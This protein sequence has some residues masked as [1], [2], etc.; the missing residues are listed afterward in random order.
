MNPDPHS[1]A[2]PL[3]RAYGT[4]PTLPARLRYMLRRSMSPQPPRRRWRSLLLGGLIMAAV[5]G[6]A[7]LTW[8]QSKPVTI[9]VDGNA[10]PTRTRAETVGDM[11]RE[12]SIGVTPSDRVTPELAAPISAD[13]IVRV[14][15]ARAVALTVDGTLRSVWT[16]DTNPADILSAAGVTLDPGDRVILDGTHSRYEDLS[17]WPVPVAAIQVRHTVSLQVDDDGAL[18]IIQ[19][20]SDTIGEALFEAGITLYLADRV[21]PPLSSRIP[22]QTESLLIRIRRAIPLTITVDGRQFQARTR[23][24]PNVTVADALAD[25]GVALIGLDVVVPDEATPITPGMDIRVI[26]VRDEIQIEQRQ[27]PFAT[28]YQPT[29]ALPSGERILRRE[30]E[31][32][33]QS[34]RWRIRYEDDMMAAQTL[35]SVTLLRAPIDRLILYGTGVS[36]SA[37]ELIND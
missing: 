2:D 16:P 11:L 12:L 6:A 10:H 32:G 4:L 37:L 24:L 7:L 20:T 18:H 23:P 19:T 15:R 29:S 25:A 5:G 17:R 8:T 36:R 34:V 13:M 9:I 30:G 22:A 1:S 3:P 27:V 21:T 35:E 28:R 33:V 31:P 26:R 14:E